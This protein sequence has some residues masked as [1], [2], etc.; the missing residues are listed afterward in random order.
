[1]AKT[2]D[3]VIFGA[4][5]RSF[6]DQG[7]V[8]VVEE[9]VVGVLVKSRSKPWEYSEH[10][11]QASTALPKEKTRVESRSRPQL[12]GQDTSPVT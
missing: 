1:M 7:D 4:V 5:S 3:C 9:P 11:Q 12:D 8:W 6:V 2:L 10:R